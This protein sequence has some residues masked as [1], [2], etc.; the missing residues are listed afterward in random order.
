MDPFR[1][2]LSLLL[3]LLVLCGCGSHRPGNPYPVTFGPGVLI[4]PTKPTTVAKERTSSSGGSC[5][6]N[7]GSGC[8]G[9]GDLAAIVVVIAVVVVVVVVIAVVSEAVNAAQ[10]DQDPD[11]YYLTLSGSG[12][13]V[14]VVPIT[15]QNRLYLTKQQYK[16]LVQ[17]VYI[18]AVLRPA[19]PDSSRRSAPT[20]E[21]TLTVARGRITINPAQ[22]QSPEWK[23]ETLPA[24]D[25]AT[26]SP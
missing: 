22:P 16:A 4:A 6:L 8:K 15:Y 12:N 3:A 13:E 5:N 10:Q 19:L 11:Q 23:P 24:T 26:S 20:Q 2:R 21:V 7:V 25:A 9:G 17:G 14:A 1:R 18:R